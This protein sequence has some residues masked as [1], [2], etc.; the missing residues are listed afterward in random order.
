LLVEREVRSADGLGVDALRVAVEVGIGDHDEYLPEGRGAPVI[1]RVT[2]IGDRL[3]C[4]Q[5]SIAAILSSGIV[6]LREFAVVVAAW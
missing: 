4:G 1:G 5:S 6:R 3:P 2:P